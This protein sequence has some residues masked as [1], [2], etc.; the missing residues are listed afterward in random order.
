MQ[1]KII[2]FELNE[3]P[4]RVI[5]TFCYLHPSSAL[6]R[7]LPYCRQYVTIAEDK[8]HLSPWK[9]WPS[10]HRGVNDEK[11][12]ICEFGQDLSKVN[13]EFPAIW[14]I[15][16]SSGVSTGVCGSL[17]TYPV[18]EN[19]TG[20]SFFLPDTFA[21][22]SECFPKSLVSFQD[23]NLRMARD[24][25][26]NVSTNL[27]WAAALRFLAAAPGLGLKL[28]T[29]GNIGGQLLSE[30]LQRWKVIRRR[31]YQVM[32]AFDI[33]MKQLQKTKP[34]FSTFFTNHVASSMHRYWAAAFPE[35]YQTSGYDQEWRNTYRNEIDFA[36]SKF[37]SWFARLVNFVDCNSGFV[38]W[39]TTSMGQ[40]ATTS[41]P[42]ETQL[43]VID[44]ARFMNALGM[45][46]T[47]WSRKP[48]MLPQINI[49]VYGSGEKL[50]RALRELCIDGQPIVFREREGLF[51]IDFGHPN[52]HVRHL[53][54]MLRGVP[55]TYA[56]LGLS[57]VNIADKSGTSAYHIPQGAL[58]I[59]DPND[60]LPKKARP[61][62]STLEIAPTIL[63]NFRL[64]IPN[65]MRQPAAVG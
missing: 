43:Y 6:S 28:D 26:R 46:S 14:D 37:N 8:T 48:A 44:L 23:F 52:L 63:R 19:L 3:V 39:I 22:G 32:I 31:T 20:Y 59:Y 49:A 42:V 62:L 12:L 65:Y 57:N 47:E 50:R 61:E 36:V 24:S 2:F 45:N 21:A 58:I 34:A 53:P 38:L 56:M 17:H 27:P 60:R 10:V 11:H 13:R 41:L 4:F 30:K 1:Q 35:D 54:P 16:A 15:L 29:L 33:F 51:S 7:T 18:P 64:T 25:A 5:D 40:S 55:V 9:T